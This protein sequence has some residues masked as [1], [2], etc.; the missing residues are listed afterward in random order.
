MNDTIDVQKHEEEVKDGEAGLDARLSAQAQEYLNVQ[1]SQT[2]KEALRA[3][4]KALIWCFYSLFTCI[5]WGYDGLASSIVLAIEQFRRDYGTK[6]NGEFVIPVI[7]QLG[8]GGASLFG[9]LFGGIGAGIVSKKWGRQLC[10][11]I[12]YLMSIAGVFL[13]YY[14]PGDLPML[15]GGK[16]LTGIPLGVFITITPTYCSEI[17]PFALRG[18]V[19]SA[20]NWSIVF[21]QCLAYVVMR[22][23]QYS[24][25][26]NAYLILFAI[27]WVFAGLA[28]LALPFFPESPYHLVSQGRFDKARAN[29]KRLY[30]A[31]F[32]V[33]GYIASIQLDLDT[34]ARTERDASYRECF[35]GK[36]NLRTLIAMSTFFV[37]SVC[38]I[39]W[40]IG[41][42]AYFLQLGGLSI[43]ASFDA[44]V[45]LS[46]LM[47]IGNMVGWIFVEKFGRRST[48]LFGSLTLTTTLL[49]IGI[50]ACI[51]TKNA[52]WAQVAFMAIWSF[53]YQSTIGSVAWPIVAEVSK[54][55]LRGHTQALAT[56]TQGI[57][58]AVSG[59]LLPFM[60]NPDQ[61]NL[62]GKVGFIYGGILGVSCVGIFFYWP[63]TKGRSFG[64][65]DELFGRGVKPRDF[66]GARLD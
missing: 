22:Q 20:V 2:W 9:L 46:F 42:M 66:K 30:D 4:P 1:R 49:L 31:K 18:S 19:T 56:V 11:L 51:Q 62:G 63:E 65:I 17:A 23:T 40:I 59:V 10:M 21:G 41:Y 33:D 27:Q 35:R 37:Q 36:N 54:S 8:L 39:G 55:S 28:L 14:S 50:S 60:V 24:Q 61:G 48:A 3:N 7:W 6:F 44:T 45:T 34:Q 53:V 16:V 25:G 15:F 26:P 5:M 57:V 38:G 43:P 52:I 47:L 13:Q 58:G 12:S 32:N 64:E 29:A